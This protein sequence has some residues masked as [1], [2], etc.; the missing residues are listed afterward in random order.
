MSTSAQPRS[1]R[2]RRLAGAAALVLAGALLPVAAHAGHL[3]FTDGP[4]GVHTNGVH[5]VSA[6]GIS[7]GCGNGSQYCPTDPVTRAQMAT[8]LHRL[9]G[10][11]STPPTVNAQTLSGLTVAQLS[12]WSLTSSSNPTTTTSASFTPLSGASMPVVIQAGHTG[13]IVSTFSAESACYG[14]SSHCSVRILVDGVE[15][16]PAQGTDFAFDSSDG[17]TET[18]ASSEG[19]AMTRSTGTLVAGTYTVSVEIAALGG[20]TLTVDDWHFMAEVKLLS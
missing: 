12:S 17:G 18:S 14:G 16:F 4:F 8:F 1:R 20:T 13:L 19:H 9:S 11:G 10:T 5:F 2:T 7:T 3:G 15:A 6:T